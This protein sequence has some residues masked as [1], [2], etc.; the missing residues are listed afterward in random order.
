VRAGDCNGL[1][2][3]ECRGG[4]SWGYDEGSER[5]CEGGVAAVTVLIWRN[6]VGVL[7]VGVAG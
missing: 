7:V 5:R 3:S 4:M 2:A 1:A 6:E